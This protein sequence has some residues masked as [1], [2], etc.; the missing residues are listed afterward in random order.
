MRGFRRVITVLVILLSQNRDG[1][2]KNDV[3]APWA[4]PSLVVLDEERKTG[5]LFVLYGDGNV[6]IRKRDSRPILH[7]ELSRS[8][9]DAFWQ[10]LSSSQISGLVDGEYGQTASEDASLHRLFIWDVDKGIR[11]RVV[12]VGP[13]DGTNRYP[14]VIDDIHR[15]VE[16][17]DNSRLRPWSP[18]IVKVFIRARVAPTLWPKDWP[19]QDGK[20]FFELD[21]SH[22][23]EVIAFMTD[24]S[25]P[26]RG[27]ISY[28]IPLPHEASWLGSAGTIPAAR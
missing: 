7:A 23:A 2:A 3:E 13:L 19:P 12:V 1:V 15:R 28:R 24:K 20:S 22:L 27:A 11:K 10:G 18:P 14:H 16:R 8:E 26:A 5:F 17:F 4:P 25:N 6:L 21:G 9:V